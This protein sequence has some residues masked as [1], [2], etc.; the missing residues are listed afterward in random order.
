MAN[1]KLAEVMSKETLSII[2]MTRCFMVFSQRSRF[3]NR[4][5]LGSTRRC[6]DIVLRTPG[7]TIFLA[8]RDINRPAALKR[9][10]TMN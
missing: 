6:H 9:R 5:E 3:E 2:V 8:H 1:A 4:L 10:Q 7:S